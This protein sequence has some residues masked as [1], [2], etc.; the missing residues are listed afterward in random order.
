VKCHIISAGLWLDQSV[1]S[2]ISNCS[3]TCK[4]SGVC[5]RGFSRSM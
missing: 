3:W 2:Y 1:Y 4:P 5:Q